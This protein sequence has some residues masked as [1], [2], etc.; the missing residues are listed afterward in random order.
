MWHLL[1]LLSREGKIDLEDRTARRSTPRKGKIYPEG[2]TARRSTASRKQARR[3]HPY[4][5]QAVSRA[6]LLKPVTG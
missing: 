4:K 1:L 3:H 6:T 2:R 5:I